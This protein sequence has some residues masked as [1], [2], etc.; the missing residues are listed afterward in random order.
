PMR[1]PFVLPVAD[2]HHRPGARR[3]E[4]L[5]A[6]LPGMALGRMGVEV[7][8]DAEIG[9]EVVLEA[10]TDGI[11]ATGSVRA[12][13]RAECRR[14]LGPVGGTARAEFRELFEPRPMEGE[15][16]PLRHEEVDLEPLVRDALLLELPLA[17][18]CRKDCRGL[19]PTC[20]A[21]LN[22]GACACVPDD[23]DPRWAALDV[24]R[25]GQ[26]DENT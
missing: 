22:E 17:P 21:D 6:R 10:V 3:G 2:L 20:G 18:L 7:P 12:T 16:W 26:K 8:P 23:R 11:L 25:A 15:T 19:C 9:L 5:S 4:V 13:F 24:W 1:R 14:C